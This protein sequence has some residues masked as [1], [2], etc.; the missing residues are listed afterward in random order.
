MASIGPAEGQTLAPHSS[1]TLTF[2]VTPAANIPKNASLLDVESYLD[3]VDP[4][5]G[6]GDT[7]A[8]AEP[9]TVAVGTGSGS[10]GGSS[11]TGLIIGI[12]AGAAVVVIAVATFLII[13]RRRRGGAPVLT[14]ADESR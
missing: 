13:A 6:S 14:G 11:S 1:T 3:Q 10:G 4:A 12:A 8:D 5:S 9:V 2:H 7:L